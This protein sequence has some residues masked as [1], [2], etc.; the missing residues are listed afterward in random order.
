[1]KRV[2]GLAARLA[3]I[4]VPILMVCTLTTALRAQPSLRITSPADGTVVRAG[5]TLTVTVVASGARFQQV[6]IISQDPIGFSRPLMAPPYEFPIEIPADIS[7]RRYWLT[8]D[9]ATAP[10]EGVR[11]DSISI[12]VERPDPPA[13]LSA[14]PSLLEMRVNDPGFL[15]VIAT[16]ADGSTADVS[17]SAT[18]VY[19]SD[20]AD[21]V[22]VTNDGRVTAVGPGSAKITI[23]NR[24]AAVV[25]P[26][27]VPQPV[28]IVPTSSSL[29]PSQTEQ[30]YA[31]VAISPSVS[32]NTSVTWSINPPLGSISN[33]GLYTPPSS[34]DSVRSVTVTATSVADN[35]K[36]ASAQVW[37]FPAISVSVAP[38]SAS[39]AAARTQQ[40]TAKVA[41]ALN[42]GVNWSVTPAGM[43]TIDAAGLYT[44]PAAIASAQTVTI[45]A[46]SRADN[47][48][49]ASA[50]V[51][52][53]P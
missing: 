12:V 23:R 37:L 42:K 46:T 4:P 35:T 29:Y 17:Q 50:R 6:I 43:G 13:R 3:A 41:Y 24:G 7:P 10:G 18:T 26:V 15:R 16:Y 9:G 1:M 39:L 44:A 19:S 40:F 22:K 8:A 36:S 47:S 32:T 2:L 28:S 31:R 11:S 38:T 45:T 20:S 52:L 51:T 5:Q 53:V 34:V 33:T 25:V 49:R 48:K 21:I 30:F 14:E 27:T